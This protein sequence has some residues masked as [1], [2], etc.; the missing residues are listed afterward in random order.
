MADVVSKKLLLFLGL[1]LVVP[2]VV[3]PL[4]TGCLTSGRRL[5]KHSQPPKTTMTTTIAATGATTHAE[6]HAAAHEVPSGPNPESN[7]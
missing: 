6:F 4:E 5:L 3:S 1:L 7:R 2:L